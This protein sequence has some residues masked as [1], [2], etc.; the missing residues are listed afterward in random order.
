MSNNESIGWV[1]WDRRLVDLY[2]ISHQH[3]SNIIYFMRLVNPSFYPEKLQHKINHILIIRFGDLLPYRPDP[4]FV[5][6]KYYLQQKGYL[7]PNG[8]IVVNG[9]KN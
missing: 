8:D 9:N 2:T 3:L 6:E 4:R 5:N 7:Q 1:T